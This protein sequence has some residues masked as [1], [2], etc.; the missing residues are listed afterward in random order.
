MPVLVN[1]TL[2]RRP[3][4]KR[5]LSSGFCE[6]FGTDAGFW[7]DWASTAPCTASYNSASRCLIQKR[8]TVD[9]EILIIFLEAE[10]SVSRMNA[11][12]DTQLL[13]TPAI[14]R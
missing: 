3:V 7:S 4:A 5:S 1:P 13:G 2:T 10:R 8:P 12:S 14:L 11:R 6:A 9:F